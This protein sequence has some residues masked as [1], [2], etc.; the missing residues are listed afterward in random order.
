MNVQLHMHWRDLNGPERAAA[1]GLGAVQ[2]GLAAL[3][4]AD[5]ATRPAAL[6]RGRKP[7]W[8]AAI[9][10]DFVGPILYL[11]KGRIFP[12]IP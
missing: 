2:V 1:V 6:V 7:L 4:W 9:A 5:L 8:A 10:V 11:T 3:A 12:R